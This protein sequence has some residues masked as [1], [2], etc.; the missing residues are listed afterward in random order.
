MLKHLQHSYIL[1]FAFEHVIASE[2]NC[3]ILAFV[4]RMLKTQGKLHW[5]FSPAWKTALWIYIYTACSFIWRWM[6]FAV[7]TQGAVNSCVTF[8]KATAGF[9]SSTSWFHFTIWLMISLSHTHTRGKAA[10]LQL[11]ANWSEADTAG[12]MLPVCT[13]PHCAPHPPNTSD[14]TLSACR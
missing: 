2:H 6:I 4:V 8:C 5:H 1:R 13:A 14:Y 10:L 7:H 12:F 11:E 3:S 9:T